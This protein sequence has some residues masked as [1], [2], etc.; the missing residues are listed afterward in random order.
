MK[1]KE[2]VKPTQMLHETCMYIID[3]EM[4]G[5]HA[6]PYKLWQSRGMAPSHVA[7]GEDALI[8]EPCELCRGHRNRT[9]EG[10]HV[11]VR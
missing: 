5:S 1:K 6:L 4:T 3:G 11:L 8:S 9:G 10:F 2:T 7:Y